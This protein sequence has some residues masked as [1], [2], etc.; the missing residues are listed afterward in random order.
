M[1]PK[2]EIVDE[3]FRK[4]KMDTAPGVSGWTQPL[5]SVA[6]RRPAVVAFVS[7][8]AGLV[9]QGSA[10]GHQLLCASRLT[11]LVKSGGGIR[12]IAVGELLFRLLA[13]VLLRHYF[14][15]NMLL[16]SQL[17]VGSKGGVEPVVRAVERALADD[18]PKSVMH[19]QW[20]VS[21]RPSPG[22]GQP[23][24]DTQTFRFAQLYL[25]WNF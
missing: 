18:L 7:V 2:S 8:L 23:W 25:R 6:L 14:K 22:S 10:P 16:P 17:G 9:A 15:P 24:I 5:L 20:S 3:V 4:F 19:F 12:P 11:P 21:E 13:K 1:A